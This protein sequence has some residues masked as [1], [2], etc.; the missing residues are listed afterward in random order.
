[1]TDREILPS[2]P[3]IQNKWYLFRKKVECGLDGKKVNNS[4]NPT[5]VFWGGRFACDF[6]FGFFFRFSFFFFYSLASLEQKYLRA[7]GKKRKRKT[8]LCPEIS[9]RMD[10][11]RIGG[12]AGFWNN[13]EGLHEGVESCGWSLPKKRSLWPQRQ[14][15]SF[16]CLIVFRVWRMPEM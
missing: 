5:L 14:C 3:R 11:N 9:L 10:L 1:M 4:E 15:H 16:Y 12:T 7:R 6:H 8:L 13:H 2:S